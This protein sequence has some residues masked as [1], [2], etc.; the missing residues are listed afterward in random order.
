MFW[1]SWGMLWDVEELE[2]TAQGPPSPYWGVLGRL[3]CGIYSGHNCTSHGT[4][5]QATIRGGV[6][7]RCATSPAHRLFQSDSRLPTSQVGTQHQA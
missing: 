6:I 7:F 3:I 1:F 4:G 5:T 2:C